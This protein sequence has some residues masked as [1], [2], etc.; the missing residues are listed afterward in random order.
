MSDMAQ[1]TETRFW[2]AQ[3]VTFSGVGTGG[4]VIYSVK[5]ENGG[6]EWRIALAS[7]GKIESLGLRNL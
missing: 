3:T 2:C 4:S 5:F 7:D 1:C 6:M